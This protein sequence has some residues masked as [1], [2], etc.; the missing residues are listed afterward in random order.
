MRGACGRDARR[1]RAASPRKGRPAPA[2]I[3]ARGRAFP[4]VGRGCVLA[5]DIAGRDRERY[6]HVAARS[7][8]PDRRSPG[9]LRRR[10]VSVRP[11]RIASRLCLVAGSSTG[12]SGISPPCVAGQVS[13]VERLPV[14][15]RPV[16]RRSATAGGSWPSIS[17]VPLPTSTGRRGGS[18]GRS[19]T[20]CAVGC[21]SP[22]GANS[23]GFGG[24]DLLRSDTVILA[25]RETPCPTHNP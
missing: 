23:R 17:G 9:L 2:A 12:T 7:S 20:A 10:A 15:S 24:V 1:Q 4:G 14:C 3:P 19:E 8:R 16:P 5:Q 22:D 13:A 6:V 21:R 11:V 25:H 18:R